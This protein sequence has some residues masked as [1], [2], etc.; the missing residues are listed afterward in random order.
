MSKNIL[1][2]DDDQRLRELL[3]DY[4]TKKKYSV[5]LAD[6]FDSAEEIINY[7]FF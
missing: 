2:I 1:I 3:D 6:D 7:F 4:L 5:Y